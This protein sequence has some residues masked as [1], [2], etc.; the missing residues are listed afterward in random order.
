VSKHWNPGRVTVELGKSRV[1]RDPVRPSRIRRDPVITVEKKAEVRTEEQEI[2]FGVLGVVLMAALL[3]ALIIGISIAT[4]FH[5]DP[6]AP[7][8]RFGQCYNAPGA[9]CVVDGD[10]AF[11]GGDRV[12][13]AGIEAPSIQDAQCTQE[14]DRGVNAAVRL[15]D[16]LNSGPVTVSRPF[17]DEYGRMVRNVAVKGQDVGERMINLGLARRY[18]G[19]KQKW[20]S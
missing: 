17:R 20:C 7:A 15:A 13:I 5:D 16:F 19:E 12:L 11:I 2:W 10:T 18:T 3:V 4:I 8:L 9:D 14:N 6:G 1:R